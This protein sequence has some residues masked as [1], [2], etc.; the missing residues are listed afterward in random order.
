MSPAPCVSARQLVP[1]VLVIPDGT[2]THAAF[3][4][5]AG[6]YM[7]S[8]QGQAGVVMGARTVRALSPGAVTEYSPQTT[9]AIAK[10][11]LD[12]GLCVYVCT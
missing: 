11:L 5:H 2:L 3:H 8:V 4:N 6:S 12:T 1:G 9:A 10:E 7:Q